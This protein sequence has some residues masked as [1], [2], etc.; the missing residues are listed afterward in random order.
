MC[1][2][3]DSWT[4][5]SRRRQRATEPADPG[6]AKPTPA[7]ATARPPAAEPRE[8]ERPRR[9]RELERLP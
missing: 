7:E 8:E 2:S 6:A 3:S 9:E 4:F 1:H 5:R